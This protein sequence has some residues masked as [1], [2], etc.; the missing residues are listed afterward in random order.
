MNKS[1]ITNLQDVLNWCETYDE[2][3]MRLGPLPV[4]MLIGGQI[5]SEYDTT[6][7]L[8]IIEE[9]EFQGHPCIRYVVDTNL[10]LRCHPDVIDNKLFWSTIRQTHPV[11]S[12]I[13]AAETEVDDSTRT[14]TKLAQMFGMTVPLIGELRRIA[15]VAKLNDP[16][17]EYVPPKLLEIGYG[18]GNIYYLTK[19][20]VD[21]T[22]IDY[23]KSENVPDTDNFIEIDVSGVP[24]SVP[25]DSQ[26][27]VYSCNTFQL[28][29]NAQRL[30]YFHDSYRVLEN[31]GLFLFMCLVRTDENR[32]HP[33]FSYVDENGIAYSTFFKQLVEVPELTDILAE[34]AISGFD[35]NYHE[36]KHVQYG[37]F[38]CRA[39]K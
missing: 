19:E 21:Y 32:S 7:V 17:G 14:S 8:D 31:D 39:R 4:E 26:Q 11:L 24:D 23:C 34:L 13:T 38:G 6:E 22:G 2:E 15:A 28:I 20:F 30:Q 9:F 5:I 36:V 27:V 37:V 10:I 35:V 33:M 18:H 12:V 29:S 25:S 3:T 1:K 16:N